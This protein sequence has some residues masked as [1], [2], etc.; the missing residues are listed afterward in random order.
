VGRDWPPLPSLQ[1]CVGRSATA[2]TPSGGPV[3]SGNATS[4]GR[5][6]ILTVQGELDL[7]TA[8]SLYLRARAAIDRHTRLLLLD[9]AGVS[10]CDVRG[11]SALVRIANDADAAGCRYGLVSPRPNVAR[12][13]RITG[14]DSRLHVFTSTGQTDASGG[15]EHSAGR[16]PLEVCRVV[17]PG[18]CAGL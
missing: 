16:Q 14:L 6:L 8:D 12:V 18:D 5:T 17:L 7:A 3:M 4:A 11:L 13:L 1:V 2:G 9:L 15:Q 10:F